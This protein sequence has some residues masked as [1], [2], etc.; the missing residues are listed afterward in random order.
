MLNYDKKTLWM[1]AG[2]D[3]QIPAAFYAKKKV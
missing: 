2:G 1:I 3:M